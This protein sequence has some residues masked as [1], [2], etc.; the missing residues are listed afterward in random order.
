MF[1]PDVLKNFRKDFAEA[2]KNLEQQYG[3]VI[4][5]G[6]IILINLNRE[7]F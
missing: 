3:V 5:L 6:N 4:D 1:T 7:V 2:V